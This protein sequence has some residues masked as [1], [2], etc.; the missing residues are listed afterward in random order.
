MSILVYVSASIAL[1]A[2]AGLFIY[3]ITFLNSSRG[4]IDNITKTVQGI[5]EE[6]QALRLSLSGTIVNLE[7]ITGKVDGTVDRLNTSMDRVNSQLTVVEGIVGSVRQMTNDVSRI[8]DDATEVVHAAR[9]VVISIVDLE[10]DIQQK[11][12]APVVEAMNLFSALGR[13]MR[14][15]REKLAGPERSAAKMDA[16]KDRRP[17]GVTTAVYQKS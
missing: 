11:V 4:L 12:Q 16:L 6:M 1:L 14:A 17:S 7:A 13:G 3:L 9:N 10:Q 8:A 15:F 5:T 2:L